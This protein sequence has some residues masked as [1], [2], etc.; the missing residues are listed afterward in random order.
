MGT[1][2]PKALLL[3]LLLLLPRLCCRHRR[4]LVL[5]WRWLS[6]SRVELATSRVE[7]IEV[8]VRLMAA[9]KAQE[10]LGLVVVPD[11]PAEAEGCGALG[12]GGG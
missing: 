5:A 2:P 12:G 10:Q 9:A 8:A 11:R 4:R 3:P 6:I 1:L 7:E